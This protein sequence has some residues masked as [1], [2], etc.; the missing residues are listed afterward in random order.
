MFP[1]Q[2]GVQGGVVAPAMGHMS[3]TVALSRSCLVR[4]DLL[5]GPKRFEGATWW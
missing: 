2:E 4:V 5:H 3:I 1:G